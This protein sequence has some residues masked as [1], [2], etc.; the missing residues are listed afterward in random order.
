[1]EAGRVVSPRW[2]ARLEQPA[3][4]LDWAEAPAA[5]VQL[6]EAAARLG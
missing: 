6:E 3:T 5:V 4:L 2:P 1:L